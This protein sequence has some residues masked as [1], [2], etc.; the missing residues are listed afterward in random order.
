MSLSCLL[1][2][3]LSEATLKAAFMGLEGVTRTILTERV[4]I[5]GVAPSNWMKTALK[6]FSFQ[7]SVGRSNSAT[8]S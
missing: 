5:I 1:L 3:Y 4:R 8:E 7:F 6:V 2:D